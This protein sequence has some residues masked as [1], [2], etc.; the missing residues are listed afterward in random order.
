[1][2]VD[3]RQVTAIVA[4]RRDTLDGADEPGR[5]IRVAI[6]F[7]GVLFSGSGSIVVFCELYKHKFA[8]KNVDGKRE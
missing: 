3:T 8:N 7:A 6:E 5:K 4:W 2:G 1:M